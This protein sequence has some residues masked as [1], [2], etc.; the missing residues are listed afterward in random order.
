MRESLLG[1]I[2]VQPAE[3]RLTERSCRVSS[4]SIENEEA[5]RRA[6]LWGML[7]LPMVKVKVAVRAVRAVRKRSRTQEPCCVAE[8]LIEP[9]CLKPCAAGFI[10]CAV[11]APGPLK[12]NVPAQAIA[13]ERIF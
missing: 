13:F 7:H 3:S 9:N 11:R 12:S 6:L 8:K 5:Q 4:R 1:S 2:W 10:A